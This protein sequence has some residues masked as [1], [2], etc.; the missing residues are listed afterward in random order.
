MKPPMNA[1]TMPMMMSPMTP[2][3]PSP[4]TA[5]FAKKPAIKPTKIQLKIPISPFLQKYAASRSRLH[6]LL[7]PRGRVNQNLKTFLENTAFPRH[8]RFQVRCRRDG[9]WLS[10]HSAAGPR[11]GQHRRY[12]ARH[13]HGHGSR[14]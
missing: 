1:P 7:L 11:G 2:P 4:G 9:G 3:G 13:D 5:Y 14:D 12:P 6:E 8:A 10:R